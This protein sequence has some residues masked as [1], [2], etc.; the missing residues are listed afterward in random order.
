MSPRSLSLR[1]RRSASPH[2][3]KG[4]PRATRARG[5]RGR[6]GDPLAVR[7]L[8]QGISS[9]L[10]LLSSFPLPFFFLNRPPTV[11]FSGSGR[12]A[13]WSA[14]GLVRTG[15]Y[16]PYC[17]IGDEKRR[18]G[19]YKTWK[20]APFP[21]LSA[22][23]LFGYDPALALSKMSSSQSLMHAQGQHALKQ[24]AMAMGAGGSQ[25]IYDGGFRNASAAQQLMY[26]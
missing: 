4:R 9:P 14:A 17:L 12:S 20:T 23:D 8:G 24:A 5:R 15:R 21:G 2:G 11:D 22:A 16:G 18:E 19:I 7:A 26:Y 6:A 3:E 13:Y 1:G 25:A 10:L